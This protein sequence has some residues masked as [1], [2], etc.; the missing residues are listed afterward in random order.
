MTNMTVWAYMFT[1]HD[2]DQLRI[3]THTGNYDRVEPMEGGKE[4]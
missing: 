4:G 3:E 1:E 2:M